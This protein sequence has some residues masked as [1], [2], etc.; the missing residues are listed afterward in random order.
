MKHDNGVVYPIKFAAVVVCGGP[1]SGE[2]AE[3][4]GLGKGDG[5]LG[6]PLPVEPR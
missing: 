2:V 1:W 3:M 4:A 6:V 5:I